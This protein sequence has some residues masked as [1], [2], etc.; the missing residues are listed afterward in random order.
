MARSGHPYDDL[1]LI[2]A[3]VPILR[4]HKD[5]VQCDLNVNN[6][7]GLRNTM[8]L[9]T[10]SADSPPVVDSRVKPLAMFIKKIAKQNDINNPFTGT[11]SR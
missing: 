9:K 2:L 3:N 11:L 8:L 4:L 10:Y 5:G 7:T 1:N 6:L